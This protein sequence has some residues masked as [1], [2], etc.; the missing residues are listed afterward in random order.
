MDPTTALGL[1]AATLTTCSFVPQLTKVWRTK[2]AE[3]LSYGMFGV[4][5]VGIPLWLLYGVL[6]G[7]LPVIIANGVTLVLSVAILVLKM[8]YAAASAGLLHHRGDSA[9]CQRRGA[10]P[11]RSRPRRQ[12]RHD[13]LGL[14]RRRKAPQ[15]AL[16]E[17][18][19]LI[20]PTVGQDGV[21]I[22]Q[23]LAR[24]LELVGAESG[25]G[26]APAGIASTAR[27]KRSARPRAPLALST[28]S[29]QSGPQSRW[30]PTS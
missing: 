22:A 21:A 23:L 13:A 5:S 15:R 24:A 28:A 2:S 30:A 6:R 8:R 4:F 25:L 27:I 29:A 14:L 17:R 7:D 16:R 1:T 3:D 18:D 19:R 12:R 9:A 20:E 11:A 26:G 10:R